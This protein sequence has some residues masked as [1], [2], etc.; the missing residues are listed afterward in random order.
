M[1]RTHYVRIKIREKGLGSMIITARKI[2]RQG[3]P[4]NLSVFFLRYPSLS[5]NTEIRQSLFKSRTFSEKTM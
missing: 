1:R 4:I 5:K 2:V 3:R